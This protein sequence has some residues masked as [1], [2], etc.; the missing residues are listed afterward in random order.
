MK[1]QWSCALRSQNGGVAETAVE[2]VLGWCDGCLWAC[3]HESPSVNSERVNMG[4][5]GIR[6]RKR[7][8]VRLQSDLS[9]ACGQ[10]SQLSIGHQHLTSS[11]LTNA[12]KAVL[13][14]LL[15]NPRRLDLI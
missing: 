2:Q 5:K 9:F 7:G 15:H 1:S 12:H 10:S 3:A 8:R 6:E 13:E 11:S 14:D 4:N